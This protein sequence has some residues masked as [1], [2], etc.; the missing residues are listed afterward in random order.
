MSKSMPVPNTGNEKVV[1]KK[2]SS[3]ELMYISDKEMP[4]V[5]EVVVE[6]DATIDIY[7][8]INSENS[9]PKI[10]ISHGKNSKSNIYFGV[11]NGKGITV[12]SHLENTGSES[13]IKGVYFATENMLF[14]IVTYTYHVAEN[15]KADICVHGALAGASETLFTG[16]IKISKAAQKTNSF[17]ANRNLL[18]SKNAT[19]NSVPSLEIDAN[20]VKASHGATIG[21]PD[22]EMIFYMMA[23]GISREESERLLI[24]AHF[25]TVLERLPE[26]KKKIF[27][28]VLPK[29]IF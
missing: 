26:D 25:S 14:N 22:E 2:G 4:D 1:A 5:L 9:C 11:Y 29:V 20:D 27:I 21:K 15:T 8:I 28:A 3:K 10:R 19:C 17:L 23:R 18:L 7:L 12:E 24:S 6:N 16:K 13:N